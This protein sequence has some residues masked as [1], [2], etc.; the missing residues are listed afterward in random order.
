MMIPSKKEI[1][2]MFVMLVA[3]GAMIGAGFTGFIWILIRS[4]G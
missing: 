1:T 2:L 3:A 4:M